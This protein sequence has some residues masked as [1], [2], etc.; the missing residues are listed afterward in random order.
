MS[1]P[2]SRVPEL[3]RT[4]PIVLVALLLVVPAFAA[5]EISRER[6]GRAGNAPTIGQILAGRGPRVARIRRMHR[7][8]ADL[9]A[10]RD[11]GSW[12]DIY[13]EWPWDHPIK[14]VKM[15][16]RKGVETIFLQTSNYG[17]DKPIFRRKRAGRLLHAAHRR[18]MRVVAWYVPSFAHPKKDR[19]RSLSAIRF[20]NR[21]GDRFD[22][23]G[24]DI[25]A[26]VVDRIPRRNRRLIRL[27]RSVRRVAGKDY[28]LGA[29]TPDPV[30]SLYWPRFPYERVRRLYDVFVPMGYFSF[31]AEGYERVRR[32]T[33]KGIRTIRQESGDPKVPIHFIGGIAGET[34]GTEVK[35]FVHALKSQEVLGGSYYDFAITTREE[36][37]QLGRIA[38]RRVRDASEAKSGTTATKNKNGPRRKG[39]DGGKERPDRSKERKDRDR[40]SK[41][42][43]DRRSG[44]DKKSKTLNCDPTGAPDPSARPGCGPSA[45]RGL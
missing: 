39:R 40:R 35:G 7:G 38:G 16:R 5:D 43:A 32:Y 27:S 29:I 2:P 24:M 13:N 33:A 31:R 3:V 15:L 4:V 30:S 34:K 14:A 19:Y 41:R 12:I 8:P 44:D 25:E 11:L 1:R 6:R 17:A 23:F 10:Y 42:N 37:Q 18:K 9:G 45:R 20:R 36:W 26:T 22:S 28:P 21:W